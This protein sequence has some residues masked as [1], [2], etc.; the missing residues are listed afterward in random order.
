MAWRWRSPA[1]LVGDGPVLDQFLAQALPVDKVIADGAYYQIDR[2][3]AL[4][5]QGIAPVIPP[6]CNAVVHGAPGYEPHDQTVQYI[7]DKG[8]V[9][10]WHKKQGYGARALVEAQ[11]SRIKRCIG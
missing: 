10:A 11:F 3:Q 6:P 8:T 7:Q 5:D 2:N 1:K 4:A 9:Y